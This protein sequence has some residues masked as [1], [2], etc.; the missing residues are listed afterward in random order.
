MSKMRF[1]IIRKSHI[2]ELSVVILQNVIVIYSH[3]RIHHEK[4]HAFE[5]LFACTFCDYKT[6]TKHGLNNHMRL[7]SNEKPY[8]CDQCDYATSHIG[9]LYIYLRDYTGRNS[10][11]CT[12]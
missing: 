12:K 8:K 4:F 5:K 1:L 11:K 6:S 10:F 2:N 3:K 9:S 7:H